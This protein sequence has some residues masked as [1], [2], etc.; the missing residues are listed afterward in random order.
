MIVASFIRIMCPD[1]LR[2]LFRNGLRNMTKSS[3][4]LTWPL[5][6]PDINLCWRSLIDAGLTSQLA[7]LAFAFRSLHILFRHKCHHRN[8]CLN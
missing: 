7:V 3:E 6:S 1:T 4:V 5:K 8:E 2:K